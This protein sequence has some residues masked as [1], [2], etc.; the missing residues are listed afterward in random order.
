MLYLGHTLLIANPTARSG[1]AEKI[2]LAAHKKL[3]ERAAQG[4]DFDPSLVLTR[5][6]G[7][8]ETIAANQG[9]AF[10]TI[11]VI[12]GDGIVHE[13]INGVMRIDREQ[14]PRIGV[15]PC[16]NGDDFARSLNLSRDPLHALDQILQG[17]IFSIDV[18]KVND[19]YFAE[20]LSF[21]FDAAIA[22]QTTELRQKTKRTGTILYLQCALDQ[23]KH[24]MVL[25]K[26]RISLDNKPATTL[27]VY[28]IAVQ[29]GQHY[30]GGFRITP[31]ASLTDGL[32]DICY[33][34]GPYLK[35][36]A[37]YIF[38]QAK[39][40]KHLGMKGVYTAQARSITLDF[41]DPIACQIDGEPLYALHYEAEVI[42]SALEVIIPSEG[43]F[44]HVHKTDNARSSHQ[45]TELA[46]TTKED[47]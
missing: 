26:V 31:N 13:V 24:N 32:F 22:L 38:L 4:Q 2:A 28:M 8:G 27:E 37:A 20:T 5:A 12:G 3:I 10:D 39:K 36:V 14:R 15:I 40:G 33:A 42:P 34:T 47:A 17:E 41:D 16:G 6:Q 35:P 9:A 23:L 30:G 45:T 18:G 29:N 43:A 19:H 46:V 25:R 21:G 7:D 11:I 1:K 44:E